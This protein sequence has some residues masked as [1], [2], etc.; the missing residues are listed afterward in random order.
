MLALLVHL[1]VLEAVGL[2]DS[3]GGQ[4]LEVLQKGVAQG[5]V[6]APVS[7]QELFGPALDQDDGY[8]DQGDADQQE[9]GA[10]KVYKPQD[11]KQRQG[12]SMA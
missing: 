9:D 7:G 10:G 3:G 4:A 5:G 8:G 6:L 11:G 2:V 12:A 1:L